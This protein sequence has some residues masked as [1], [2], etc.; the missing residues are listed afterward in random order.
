MF[1][2]I[3][4]KLADLLFP[5]VSSTIDDLEKKYPPR[6]L[7]DGAFVTRLAPSPT[8]FIH[9]GNLF[10]A[11]IDERLAHQSNG[12]FY[13]RIEDTDQKRK[14]D[15]AI[16]LIISSL[17]R[18]GFKFD[19]GYS[20]SNGKYGPYIQSERKNIY[21]IVAKYLVQKGLAYPCFCSEDELEIIRTKQTE[22]NENPGYYGKWATCRTL[23]FENIKQNIDAG[24]PYVIR[25]KSMGN[26]D[27]VIHATDLVKGDLEIPENNL[28]IVLLKS[29][30]IPTYHFAHVVDDHFMRT[31]HVVRGEEWLSTFP[32]HLQLFEY[33]GWEPPKFIHTSHMMKL[34]GDV[35]RKLSKRKDPEFGMQY[36]MQTGYP[37]NAVIEYLLTVLNSNFEEWRMANPN[38][39]YC[40]FKFT[41]DKMSSSGSLFDMDKF[42]DISKNVVAKMSAEEVYNQSLEWAQEYDKVLYYLILSAPDYTKAILSIG[43]G[44]AK[45]RKDIAFWSE[46]KEYMGFFFDDLFKPDYSLPDRVTADDAVLILKN[47]VDIYNSDDTQD[48]WFDK[49]KELAGKYG[50]A[51]EMK[52]YRKNPEL[53]KGNVADIAMILRIAV[54]GKQVSPDTYECMRIL[55]KDKVI[56]RLNQ[57]I[58]SIE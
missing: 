55:G 54:T 20:L 58:S 33:I 53:Y 19:E 41:V 15:G 18:F 2:D 30:G 4:L 35:K 24:K 39:E 37:V 12:I 23:S 31:T 8:G 26:P 11:L 38:S 47:Y 22:S 16:E 52:L 10:G 36:Y 5:D 46:L 32:W 29:D 28:D 48:V 42:I 14:V 17:A 51:S 1:D 43:R 56:E 27:N 44:G 9:L 21:H 50:F 6:N 3:N 57:M 45:P 13:L 49:L 40:D 7:P 25:L 34:D